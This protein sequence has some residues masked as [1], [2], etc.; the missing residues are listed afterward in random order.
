MKLDRAVKDIRIDDF[1][2]QINDLMRQVQKCAQKADTDS[3]LLDMMKS[4]KNA[5]NTLTALTSDFTHNKTRQEIRID[6]ANEANRVHGEV[7]EKLK[8]QAGIPSDK[9][10]WQGNDAGAGESPMVLKLRSEI[11]DIAFELRSLQRGRDIEQLHSIG[12]VPGVQQIRAFEE[13]QLQEGQK[14]E[15]LRH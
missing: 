14:L 6:K 2:D 13:R 8:K 5:T 1:K 10:W 4:V 11:K 3:R 15:Q 7:L 9:N 12:D